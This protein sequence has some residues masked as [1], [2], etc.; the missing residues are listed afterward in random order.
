MYVW[1]NIYK[2]VYLCVSKG[3]LKLFP[4]K[5]LR[6]NLRKPLQIQNRLHRKVNY[7]D[8]LGENLLEKKAEKWAVEFPVTSDSIREFCK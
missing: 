2:Y 4:K 1:I 7:L 5:K 6:S 3:G 8:L